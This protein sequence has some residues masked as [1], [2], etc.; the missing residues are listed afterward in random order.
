M[1]FNLNIDE[2]N[3]TGLIQFIN[4]LRN[5]TKGHGVIQ[6]EMADVII[7]MLLY[8]ISFIHKFLALEK[9]SCMIAK[10]VC[11][12]G[13]EG[14]EMEGRTVFFNGEYTPNLLWECK[15]NNNKYMNFFEGEYIVPSI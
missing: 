2:F 8:Y 9:F 1:P 6:D 13:Y 15:K 10:D 7:K 14:R 4:E 5:D 3:F 11:L 12:A